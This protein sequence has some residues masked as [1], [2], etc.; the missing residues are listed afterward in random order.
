[1]NAH[2]ALVARLPGPI[3]AE[4]LLAAVSVLFV[5]SV[6]DSLLMKMQNRGWRGFNGLTPGGSPDVDRF[7]TVK[8]PFWRVCSHPIIGLNRSK[9]ALLG[10][11]R[12]NQYCFSMQPIFIHSFAEISRKARANG[13]SSTSSLPYTCGRC[14]PGEHAPRVS[15]FAGFQ[16]RRAQNPPGQRNRIA[17]FIPHTVPC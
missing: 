11:N 17:S 1:M 12:S 15:R 7:D 16:T 9:S 6:V 8:T 10:V 3:P 13:H 14:G 4:L 5:T 2:H